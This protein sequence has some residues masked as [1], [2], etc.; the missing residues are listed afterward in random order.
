[1]VVRFV[2]RD[3]FMR[4][5]S[6]RI[7]HATNQMEI[8]NDEDE[9]DVD[10]KIDVITSLKQG[11]SIGH[12]LQIEEDNLLE[13]LGEIAKVV[14]EGTMA[15]DRDKDL[16]GCGSDYSEDEVGVGDE[17]NSFSDIGSHNEDA[18]NHGPEDGEGEDYID[19]GCSAQ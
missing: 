13:E 14:A 2:D 18:L 8:G 10:G 11:T 17:D 15:D 4:Y 5:A 7:G 16:V 6:S 12:E 1:M 9:V 19:N 3:M